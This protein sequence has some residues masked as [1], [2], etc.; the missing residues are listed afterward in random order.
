MAGKQNKLIL[1]N[2]GILGKKVPHD[3]GKETHGISKP[4][5]AIAAN[6]RLQL[7]TS[8]TPCPPPANH[9]LH[10]TVFAAQFR[11]P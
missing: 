8:H 10:S 3:T 5:H 6:H 1:K 11:R 7:V 2:Y 4:E 9:Q